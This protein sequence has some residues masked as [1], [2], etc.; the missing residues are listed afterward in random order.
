MDDAGGENQVHDQIREDFPGIVRKDFSALH[1]YAADRT[2][3][4]ETFKI[5]QF[6]E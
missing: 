6:S 4:H 3:E 5:Q 2:Q 1:D